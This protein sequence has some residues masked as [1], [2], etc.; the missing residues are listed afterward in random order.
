MKI[1]KRALAAIAAVFTVAGLTFAG[2]AQAA[3]AAPTPAPPGAAAQGSQAKAPL[4]PGKHSAQSTA[5]KGATKLLSTDAAGK[6]VVAS[7]RSAQA[8]NVAGVDFAAPYNYCWKQFVYTPVT[9]TTATTRY[10]HV[11]LWN[12]GMY[13]DYYTSVGAYSTSYP[14]WYGV[15]GAYTA[16]LYVWNGSSYVYDE[17]KSSNNTCSVSVTRNYDAYGWVR[18]RIQ[19]TG[20]AYATQVTSELAP[21]P[22]AGTY[23]GTKYH[24]PAAGGAAIEQ[25]FQVDYLP[26]GITS[27][28]SDSW[29]N[30]VNFTGDH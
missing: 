21:Y 8:G 14:G 29:N 26:Y 1:R 30:Q 12:Q 18:V 15:E 25:W 28:T 19:N 27:R 20:T 5:P 22:G 17:Y 6:P 23:T 2:V 9:N 4:E 10:L 24:Y 11:L 3:P 7:D 16:Y 13:R